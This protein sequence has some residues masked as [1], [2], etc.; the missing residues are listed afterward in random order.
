MRLREAIGG[1]EEADF[2]YNFITYNTQ[3]IMFQTDWDPFVEK[4]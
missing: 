2:R 3:S 1:A 4:T